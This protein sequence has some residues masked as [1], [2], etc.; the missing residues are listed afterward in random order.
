MSVL[1][2]GAYGNVGSH[3]V[4]ELLSAG[5]SVRGTSRTPRTG[6]LPDAVEMVRLDLGDPEHLPAALDGIKKVFL[7]APPG[8]HQ[9][10]R[11]RGAGGR[12]RTHRAAL[13][14]RRG[15]TRHP[16][17]PQRADALRGGGSAAGI[18]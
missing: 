12:G 13:V 9:R 14:G 2:I 1:V 11:Q 10:V 18:R 17:Q 6:A 7:Y 15:R 16:K 8:R 5:T 4:A 3:V